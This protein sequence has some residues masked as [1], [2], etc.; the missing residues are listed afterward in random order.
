MQTA[1]LYCDAGHPIDRE[2]GDRLAAV[3]DLVCDIWSQP[4]AGIWEVRG[5]VRHFTQSKM[6]C[7][8]ALDRAAR[9]A[10]AGQIPSRHVERWRSEAGSIRSF[11]EERCWS[12]RKQSYARSA[13]TDELDASSP[14]PTPV[15]RRLR[16]T[17]SSRTGS[18]ARSACV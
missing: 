9:L 17:R 14:G 13:D 5:P 11:I 7:W 2:F 12:E 6:M 18:R 15:A 16:A 4:D 10:A 3:A 8:V 1:W